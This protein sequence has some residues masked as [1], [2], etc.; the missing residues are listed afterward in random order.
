MRIVEERQGVKICCPEE[1]AWR[2]GYIGDAELEALA[3]PLRASGYGD[4]LV[5]LLARG[6]TLPPVVATGDFG[7]AR[8]I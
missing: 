3:G 8:P 1:I 4:Y 2:Q 5:S 6:Q 7:D